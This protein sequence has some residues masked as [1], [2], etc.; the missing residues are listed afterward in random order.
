MY[1]V[2]VVVA[3]AELLEF[4]MTSGMSKLCFSLLISSRLG[5]RRRRRRDAK[6]IR[7]WSGVSSKHVYGLD[8][9]AWFVWKS[10]Y[11]S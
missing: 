11:D 10:K 4:M 8:N 6:E 9:S 7:E 5:R 1:Q 2:V 3:A